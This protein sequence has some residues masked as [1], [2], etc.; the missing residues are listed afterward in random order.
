MKERE[1]ERARDRD[2]ARERER[3]RKPMGPAGQWGQ[4]RKPMGPAGQWGQERKPMGPGIVVKQR[5]ELLVGCSV[6]TG[7]HFIVLGS[8]LV[9]SGFSPRRPVPN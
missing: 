6:F 8:E 1:R 5:T 7:L 2:K 3:E 4:E 9:P